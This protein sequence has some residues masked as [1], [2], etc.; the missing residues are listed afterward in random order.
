MYIIGIFLLFGAYVSAI[1]LLEFNL[2][3]NIY[4]LDEYNNTL[5]V[6]YTIFS[7]KKDKANVS[8]Y[9][10]IIR[11][12]LYTRNKPHDSVQLRIGDTDSLRLGQFD[13]KIPTIFVTH[14][15]SNS[16]QSQ[17]C[18]YVRDA[19]LQHGEYNVI[20][21]DW[22]AVSM[23]TYASVTSQVVPVSQYIARMIDFLGT[24]GV[25]SSNIT[26][27]GHSVGAHIAGLSSYYA[28]KKANYVVGL[29]PSAPY[30]YNKSRDSQ[31]SKYDATYVQVIHTSSVAGISD[32]IGDVD[33]YV[34]GALQQNGCY[35]IELCSHW[36]A[37]EYFAESV[38]S[39]GFLARRCNNF[40]DYELGKCESNDV[41]YM[42]GAVLDHN[43]K[44]AYYLTV[45]AK[46]PF[47]RNNPDA[48]KND[49]TEV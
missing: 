10:N 3:V 11:F 45:N 2:S 28:K 24:Q 5:E 31:I 36:R 30:F 26:V 20:L 19:Y 44:G 47:A 21:I 49:T 38:K 14:G 13:P 7:T 41:A 27:I 23:G 46:P 32:R 17:S 22:S 1:E 18:I 33:F 25:D 48:L 9:Q 39:G 34:D 35:N 8:D 6:H 42:G 15:W 16:H 37:Y 40:F 29:D 12:Y 4:I 43:A